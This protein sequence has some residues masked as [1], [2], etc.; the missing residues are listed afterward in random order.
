MPE[1]EQTDSEGIALQTFLKRLPAYGGDKEGET[2]E[3]K[4]MGKGS[5][6][7][8]TQ[9]GGF[10]TA[11]VEAI[12]DKV[13]NNQAFTD[14]TN[15]SHYGL[16]LK[17]VKDRTTTCNEFCTVC[18]QKMGYTGFSVGKFDIADWLTRYGLGHCW[19]R[20]D[21][22]DTPQYGDIF[23]LYDSKPDHN[24]VNL[25]HMGVSLYIDGKNWFTA[26]SG[27]GGPL[28][29]YDAIKRK[30]RDWM[31]STLQGWVSMRALIHADKPTSP[32]VGGW[33]EVKQG[34]YDT[35]YYYFSVGNKVICTQRAPAIVSAPPLE[36]IVGTFRMKGMFEMEI[37]WQ[38]EDV[39]ETITAANQ[40]SKGRN[41]SFVGKTRNGEKLVG[42]RLMIKGL[43]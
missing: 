9:N 22:G 23:R 16:L 42:K 4:S 25:N 13:K 43:L 3:V 18:A 24:G 11:Q 30:R 32:W 2:E 17:W 8:N 33:W 12:K 28:K 5:E 26:E 15:N 38:S 20:A 14:M 40:D 37:R 27:Q 6:T 10:T 21:S 29:G 19:V 31:P 1:P 36:G 41:Y 34:V 7:L 39:D 35:W